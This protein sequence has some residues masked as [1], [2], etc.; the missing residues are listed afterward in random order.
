MKFC[1][2]LMLTLPHRYDRYCLIAL[3]LDHQKKLFPQLSQLKLEGMTHLDQSTISRLLSKS[4]LGEKG[5]RNRKLNRGSLLAL[6]RIG[7]EMDHY[8]ASLM[9][10]LSEGEEYKPWRD[11]EFL[12]L[13][14]P[15]PTLEERRAANALNNDPW[16][17]HM[18]IIDLLEKT[19]PADQSTSWYSVETQLLQGNS[20]AHRVALFQKLRAME[21]PPGQRM[22]VSKYP[23]ILVSTDLSLASELL[24]ETNGTVGAELHQML[25]ERQKILRQ[26]LFRYGERAIHSVS[27]LTRFVKPEFNHPIPLE[28][29]RNRVSGLIEFLKGYEKFQVGLLDAIEPETEIAIKSTQ[30]AVIRGTARELSNH[31]QT[32]VCGPSYI[33]WRDERAVLSFYL[34]FERL[35]A[36][37]YQA[38]LTEKKR[39]ITILKQILS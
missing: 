15:T 11:K 36:K 30:A 18:A 32:A 27:S 23:S 34:G 7:L 9:L 38:G 24:A 14:L 37:L 19:C 10:W 39:V 17:V 28:E 20:P 35:W 21:D 31:P 8:K 4:V 2:F 25:T 12:D 16:Q 6:T 3:V 33:Y 29:R 1:K 26:N 22:L 13:Q 5:K